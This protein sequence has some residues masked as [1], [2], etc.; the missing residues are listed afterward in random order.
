MLGAHFEAEIREQP[1]VWRRIAAS[2]GAQRFAASVAGRDVLFVGSGSSLFV[3]MLGAL[4]FRRRGIRAS[5]LAA[6][7]TRFDRNA[8]DGACVVA[9]SQSGRSAD[10]LAAIDL[11]APS[12]LVALTS[13]AASPLAAR[14]DVV[15]D[16][17]AGPEL[18]VPASKSVT[19]MAAILL[20]AA[21]LT[22][23]KRNR[24]AATLERT[25]DDVSDWLDGDGVGDVVAAA[26]RI[27]RR[28]SVALVAAGYGVPVAYEL[29]LK[30]KEASYVHAEGFAA[31]EFR[32]GS[33]AMLDAT[34]A[35]IGIV[36]ESSRD[37]VH[38][39]LAEAVEAEAARYVIGAH[40]GDVQLIGP[41]TGEA[42][43]TL[44]WL[45]AGQYLALSIG[46][47]NYV[48]SDAPRGLHKWVG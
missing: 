38:R 31:G 18:A 46:R 24:T 39:P 14:A 40:S 10:L 4:A 30:I 19:S 41:S 27:A 43:N 7:E 11:L 44:A 45:V 2:D 25:A 34:T 36:D 12:R 8:Y 20:W 3:G 47:A 28:R 13:D 1:D 32:H 33:S 26:R 6:T 42:F 29:A 35:I 37:I 5:A 16:S 15:I 9:L 23:G 21:A 48:E 17:L 22:G